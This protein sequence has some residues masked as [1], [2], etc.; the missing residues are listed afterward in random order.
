MSRYTSTNTEYFREVNLKVCL[1][2][3]SKDG[4]D[5]SEKTILLVGASAKELI[6]IRIL[7]LRMGLENYKFVGV[8]NKNEEV[9]KFFDYQD[10]SIFDTWLS[11]GLA[12]EVGFC[13]EDETAG[14]IRREF[15]EM[16]NLNIFRLNPICFSNVAMTYG[17]IIDGIFCEGIK[18]DGIICNNVLIHQTETERYFSLNEILMMLD[19]ESYFFRDKGDNGYVTDSFA[20][21]DQIVQ[22]SIEIHAPALK[23]ISSQVN[24][25]VKAESTPF[26]GQNELK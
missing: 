17:D 15:N 7:A 14:Y 4:T 8:N 19:E 10:G 16:L 6:S 2:L 13:E 25:Y 20:Y 12:L 21:R 23:R 11:P 5:H 1:D 26:M 22:D 18:F 3:L 24:V 9:E